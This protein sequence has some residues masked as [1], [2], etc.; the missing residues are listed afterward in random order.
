[1]A[2]LSYRERFPRGGGDAWDDGPAGALLSLEAFGSP[3]PESGGRI[4]YW[5][6]SA[7]S[8]A[9]LR[10]WTGSVWQAVTLRYWNGSAWVATA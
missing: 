2:D 1:M 9:T 6:G 5:T 7:W 8:Y 10:R 4:R 3:P